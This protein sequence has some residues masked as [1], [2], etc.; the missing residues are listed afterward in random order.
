MSEQCKK[1]IVNITQINKIEDRGYIAKLNDGSHVRLSLALA[2]FFMQFNTSFSILDFKEYIDA[3]SGSEIGWGDIYVIINFQLVQKNIIY[4]EGKEPEDKK[5]NKRLSMSGFSFNIMAI[6]ENS[7]LI[8]AIKLEGL[9]ETNIIVFLS[10]VS[11]L[12]CVA[13][14]FVSFKTIKLSFNPSA[15]YLAYLFICLGCV[16][17]EIGHISACNKFNVK[18]SGVGM[19]IFFIFLRIFVKIDSEVWVKTRLQRTVIDI[20]G[21]YFQT[22][23]IAILALLTLFYPVAYL[24][25]KGNLY[26]IILNLCPIFFFDGKWVLIDLLGEKKILSCYIGMIKKREFTLKKISI[27]LGLSVYFIFYFLNICRFFFIGYERA[28]A[29]PYACNLFWH[30]LF[31]FHKSYGY[32]SYLNL[33]MMNVFNLFM[34]LMI[35][36]IVLNIVVSFTKQIRARLRY[37]RH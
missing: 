22:I 16:V 27:L 32:L 4:E 5:K 2:Q 33:I 24:G 29:L 21:I 13:M 30:S 19:G 8:N 37:R 17:H 7:K 18:I 31:S 11:L 3:Y 34:S 12:T 6:R 15:Y 26:L 1:Y 35:F 9:F 23:Y 36:I 20:A 25:F 28:R 10:M 14:Y